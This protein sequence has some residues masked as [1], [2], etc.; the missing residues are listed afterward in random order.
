MSIFNETMDK[1]ESELLTDFVNFLKLENPSIEFD[2]SV[3]RFL[4][5]KPKY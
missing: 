3:E 2:G 1:I 4:D 5:S